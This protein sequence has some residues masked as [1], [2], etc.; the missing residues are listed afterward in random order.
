MGQIGNLG[1]KTEDWEFR[2]QKS[3]VRGAV[4]SDGG[5]FCIMGLNHGLVGFHGFHGFFD[6]GRETDTSAEK[7]KRRGE[8]FFA[9]ESTSCVH[10]GRLGVESAS[11]V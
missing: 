7:G 10:F 8:T 3:E 11:S 5:G 4:V 9:L 1:R 6:L 2:D